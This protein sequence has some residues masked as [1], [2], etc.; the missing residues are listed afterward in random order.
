MFLS[1]FH[2]CLNTG[3]HCGLHLLEHLIRI[4]GRG[5]PSLIGWSGRRCRWDLVPVA[6]VFVVLIGM[7]L[8]WVEMVVEVGGME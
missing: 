4:E 6:L 7:L 5:R 3:F 8:T 2:H 1:L